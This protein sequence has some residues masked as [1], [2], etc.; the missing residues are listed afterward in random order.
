M[1]EMFLKCLERVL[2][3]EGGFVDHPLDKGGPTNYGITLNTLSNFM[4]RQAT[5]EELKTLSPDIVRT[6]YLERYWLPMKL[7][8]VGNFYI[9]LILFDQA[10]NRGPEAAV[11]SL[12]RALNSMGECLE[13]DGELGNKTDAA[14]VRLK[15]LELFFLELIE[16]CTKAYVSICKANPA[17]IVFMNGWLSRCFKLLEEALCEN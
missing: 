4:R 15:N 16:E 6:I 3:H 2:M 10:V 5:V 8:R 13:V 12:Q 9:A 11:K 14:M 7:D 17:Q 1:S